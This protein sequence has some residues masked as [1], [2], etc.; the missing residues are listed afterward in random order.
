MSDG[1]EDQPS[2][3]EFLT[4]CFTSLDITLFLGVI[5]PE[6]EEL[7]I[8]SLAPPLLDPP[9]DYL[10]VAV[11]LLILINSLLKV[12]FQPTWVSSWRTVC[13]FSL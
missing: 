4:E 8:A 5:L 10:I 12:K 1:S 6:S 7:L 3:V 9:V 11:S 2:I 13:F